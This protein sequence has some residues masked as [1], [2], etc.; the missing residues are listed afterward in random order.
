M[1]KNDLPLLSC[2]LLLALQAPF[3]LRAQSPDSVIL[4]QGHYHSEA[5][6]LAQL[7]RFA[8]N[9]HDT[10]TWEARA[11][12]IRAGIRKGLKL[13]NEPPRTDLNARIRSKKEMDGY[14][15]ENVAFESLPGFWVTG[16]LYRPLGKQGPFAGILS[17]HGHWSKPED[18]GRFRED[19]QMR[20]ASLARMGAVVFAWDMLGYGESDQCDHKHPQALRLQTWNSL[21]A[22]DFLLS[23]PDVDP[24]RIGATGASGGGTQTFLLA[25]L[26]DRIA[27]SVPVVMV[28]A[29]FFG[30][31]VCESGMPIHKSAQHETNNVEIAALIAPKPLML[32]SDGDDWT[33]NTPQVEYPHIRSI[34]RLYGA[35]DQVEH[36]HLPDEKHDYGFSK[37][38]AA[39]PFLAK[40]LKLDLNA[41]LDSDGEIDESFVELL[42]RTALEVFDAAHPRPADAVM[43]D[44]AVARLLGK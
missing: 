5:E 20:C 7:R 33:K 44:E 10:T 25:A 31:C 24:N 3:A 2:L 13:E 43:G 9:Y 30:G 12:N 15:V 22:L 38:E 21:R 18:Y 17:P 26:D 42:P 28:S 6:G 32:I 37:R 19:M 4:C 35:T 8:K 16:N 29:H 39:Y 40:H 41:I 11:A 23:L 34:Y 36:V 1:M 27:V 14:T